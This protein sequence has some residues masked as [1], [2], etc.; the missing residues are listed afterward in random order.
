MTGVNLV[1]ICGVHNC[2]ALWMSLIIARRPDLRPSHAIAH[3]PF[4]EE[5]ISA[6]LF[7]FGE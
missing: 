2:G 5:E 4:C 7:Q 1:H 3:K 6:E